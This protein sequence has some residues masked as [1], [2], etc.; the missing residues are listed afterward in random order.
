MYGL[1]KS[2]SV[3]VEMTILPYADVAFLG[4]GA[5][6]IPVNIGIEM[7]S[8]A[9]AMACIVSGRF[10]GH[11]LP[12][13]IKSYDHVWL[14]LEGEYRARAAD[15]V[16]EQ[17]LTGRGGGQY[18]GECGGGQRRWMWRDFES[19]LTSMAI[20]G[21]LRVQHCRDWQEGAQWIKQLYSWFGKSEHKSHMVMY[22]GPGILNAD[23]AL[24]V[25]PSLVRRLAAELPRIG[26]ERSVDV[27]KRFKSVNE[28]IN[29]SEREWMEIPGIGKGIAATV[30]KAIHNNSN[31]N[32]N[33]GKR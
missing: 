27:D 28:M 13:L 21:S 22:S 8:I 15:G 10:A 23:S 2:L 24:L 33:G 17:R 16:L 26:I 6:G 29:A 19:W 4:Q 5:D 14:L 1:L 20:M 25:K 31:G 7:K 18:W 30:Y 32:G 11:Q 12:G 9:D 3:E